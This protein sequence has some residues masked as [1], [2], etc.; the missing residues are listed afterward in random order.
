M[1]GQFLSGLTSGAGQA[2]G[3]N[4]VG[5]AISALT[6]GMKGRPQWRDISF[7]NDVANRLTP[8]EAARQNKF[9][10]ITQ[11]EETRRLTQRIKSMGTDLGMSPWELTGT[12]GATPISAPSSGAGGSG[13]AFAANLV[14]LQIAKMNN[15][16]QLQMAAMSN[17]TQR[18]VAGVSPQKGSAQE[19]NIAATNAQKSLTEALT[20]ESGNRSKA[21]ANETFLSN[22]RILLDSRPTFTTSLPGVTMTGKTDTYPVL[23]ALKTAHTGDS[24]NNEQ[25]RR[26]VSQLNDKRVDQLMQ[27]INAL[28]SAGGKTVQTLGDTIMNFLPNM[29]R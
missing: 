13:S 23:E 14:P 16:T 11:P 9:L 17:Q 25:L 26:A 28:A 5:T 3:S 6:G 2:A 1:I 12:P 29:K 24:L 19:A 18:E 21:I 7:M 4:L 15:Q 10:D 22:L 27:E 20:K 8:D